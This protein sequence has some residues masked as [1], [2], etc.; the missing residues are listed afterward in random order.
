MKKYYYSGAGFTLRKMITHVKFGGMCKPYKYTNKN[1]VVSTISFINVL[2]NGY[3]IVEKN[4]RKYIRKTVE[5][6]LAVA[7]EWKSRINL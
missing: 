1:S 7:A 6:T 3:F 5:A 2:G 4:G